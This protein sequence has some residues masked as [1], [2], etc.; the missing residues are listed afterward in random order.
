MFAALLGPT[1]HENRGVAEEKGWYCRG[2]VSGVSVDLRV[3]SRP[4]SVCRGDAV[5]LRGRRSS[6]R[7]SYF[8]AKMRGPATTSALHTQRPATA[9]TSGTSSPPSSSGS[10]PPLAPTRK[11]PNG[12]L[13][14]HH[15]TARSCSE[16]CFSG[17]V[18]KKGAEGRLTSDFCH[19]CC[20]SLS[21]FQ[22]A[23]AGGNS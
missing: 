5:C 20:L 13:K 9:A 6:R 11:R 21:L 19:T 1:K 8:W 23:E 15:N 3:D 10:S 7:P 22:K 2:W 4:A 16:N 12:P 18:K 17:E 14:S